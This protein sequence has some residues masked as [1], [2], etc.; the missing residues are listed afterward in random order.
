[1]SDDVKNVLLVGVGGQGVLLVGDILCEVAMRSG[2][3]A[4]KSEIHGLA[5]RGGVVFSHVRFGEKVYS[6][7][8]TVG[9]GDYIVAFEEMEALRWINF[10]KPGGGLILNTQKIIH[11]LVSSGMLEYPKDIYEKLKSYRMD[12]YPVDALNQAIELGNKHL[13]SV[14]LIGFLSC[15][16]DFSMDLWEEVI[17]NQVPKGTEKLNL[18]AFEKGRG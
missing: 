18:K 1:V 3:E 12:I 17:I 8:I 7:L 9:E 4:K 14:V 15:F 13:V 2:F 6:P 11:P 10:L 5:V 16:F